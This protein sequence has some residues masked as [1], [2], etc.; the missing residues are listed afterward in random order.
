MAGD[1]EGQKVKVLRS[2]SSVKLE[3]TRKSGDGDKTEHVL[4]RVWCRL[5]F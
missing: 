4:T 2:M 5:G 3:P 1:E